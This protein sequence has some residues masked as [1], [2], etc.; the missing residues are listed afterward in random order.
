VT[1]FGFVAGSRHLLVMS[2]WQTLLRWP[3][4]SVE[5]RVEISFATRNRKS[6]DA[7]PQYSA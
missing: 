1:V 2:T 5:A 6:P 7:R 4:V 3:L